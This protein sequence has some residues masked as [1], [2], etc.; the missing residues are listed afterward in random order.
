MKPVLILLLI[1]ALANCSSPDPSAQ[2]TCTQ[3]MSAVCQKAASCSLITSGRVGQCEQSAN[4]GS[5][6][7]T[8]SCSESQVNQ[9]LSDIDNESCSSFQATLQGTLPASCNGC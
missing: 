9:C 3:T 8:E 6:S 7:G 1:A 4:C 2:D 5:Q